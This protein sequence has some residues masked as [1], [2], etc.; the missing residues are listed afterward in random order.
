MRAAP[1]AL[2][3]LALPGH[4]ARGMT[5]PQARPRR[6]PR[7]RAA[8]AEVHDGK[9]EPP[10]RLAARARVVPGGGLIGAVLGSAPE[11]E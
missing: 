1:A 2:A 11:G 5:W 9:L 7:T 6:R 4:A 10:L 8:A 3:A